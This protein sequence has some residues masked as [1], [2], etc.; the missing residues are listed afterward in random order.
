MDPERQ[1]RR[2]AGGARQQHLVHCSSC[3]STPTATARAV[4]RSPTSCCPSPVARSRPSRASRSSSTRSP[5]R[6]SRSARRPS[7]TTS[8]CRR[9]CCTPATTACGSP[10]AAAAEPAT[11]G[12]RRPR[13]PSSS[14]GPAAAG[15]RPRSSRRGR[16]ARRRARRASASARCRAAA[17]GLAA[18][19]LRAAP[20][21]RPPGD[22]RS[23]RRRR[24]ADVL[25][26][27]AVDGQPTRTIYTRAQPGAAGS[28][29]PSTWAR[30][31]GRR[32]ASI[33]IARGGDVAWGEP[34]IVVKAP[35]RPAAVANK[36]LRPHLRLDGRHAARR[37]DARLQPED[38]RADAELRRL[39]GRRDALRVGA[40]AG[41]L[42]AALARVAADRR[43][44]DACTRP[45]RTRR[46]C[47]RTCP[48]SPRT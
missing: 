29:P 4:R 38:A 2:Q 34:R 39:R 40:G 31:R 1:G 28:T 18:V 22:R 15:R 6:P 17:A 44:P 7:A 47:P 25:V 26:R 8:T 48:S 14:L 19:V 3:P 21:D 16:G 35:P 12:K 9:P 10:S 37:Q 45:S 13:S 24:G 32:R 20:R 42:V 36:K 30:R 46:A 33:S 43:L 41:H 11:A 5:S 27:V 23:A